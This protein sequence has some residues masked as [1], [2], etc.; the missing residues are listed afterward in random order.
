MTQKLTTEHGRA[1]H[2]GTYPKGGVSCSKDSFVVNCIK[3][4]IRAPQGRSQKLLRAYR[5]LLFVLYITLK[6]EAI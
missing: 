3:R 1:A 5:S 4:C 6:S 2:N